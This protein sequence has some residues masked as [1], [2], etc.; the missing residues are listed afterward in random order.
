MRRLTTLALVAA[1]ACASAGPPPGGPEDHEP[2]RI[3]AVN[4]DSGQ[5][6]AKVRSV[7]FR[8]DEVVSDRPASSGATVSQLFL[9]SPRNG[10]PRASWRRSRITVRPE[11][12]FRDNT[13]YKITL[14]PGLADLRGNRRNE[15]AVVVFSTGPSF[16]PFS[17]PGI[18]F[19]WAAERP[20]PNAYV[21]AVLRS[22]TSVVYLGMT[23][24]T[25][26]FDIGPLNNGAYIVR[27]VID[28]NN[29]RAIDRNEKWDSTLVTITNARQPVELDAIERDT[30]P[31]LLETVTVVD[32]VTLRV[33][34]D[35]ALDP[36]LPLQPALVSI[37]RS[38]STTL[39]V[40]G[41]QWASAY[42][43]ARRAADSTHRADS[44]RVADSARAAAGQPGANRP[45]AQPTPP[46]PVPGG[47]RP[48][49]PPPK[50]RA[51]APD[52]GIVVTLAPGNRFVAGTEYRVTTR[53]IRNLLGRSHEATRVFTAPRPQ[54]RPPTDTVRRGP[55]GDMLR[56]PPGDSNRRPPP[57]DRSKK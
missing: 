37:K 54:V 41:I 21:E 16:P 20:A 40:S 42:D 56:R 34:F 25:G 46:I 24:S 8:F 35:K 27:A 39:D 52:R 38:D 53:A 33:M 36:L 43:R 2:P 10:T 30:V 31:P 3:I 9:I 6:N 13:T 44:I 22:D 32:S 19:D 11:R 26:R 29:N 48:A 5:V 50:P 23:D 18:V 15:P 4:P 55:P 14:L 57:L 12:G 49:P 1:A 17:I 47:A 28:Q 7:E 45:A 51:P